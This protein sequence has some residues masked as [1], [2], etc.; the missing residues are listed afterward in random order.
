MPALLTNVGPHDGRGRSLASHPMAA[1]ANAD[2]E[3]FEVHHEVADVEIDKRIRWLRF[4]IAKPPQ[5]VDLGSP[6]VSRPVGGIEDCFYRHL[7]VTGSVA[8]QHPR[9]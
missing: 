1:V 2:D 8:D 5:R 9:L 7:F 3:P 4:V 6:R